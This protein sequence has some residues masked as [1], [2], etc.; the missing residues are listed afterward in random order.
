MK[1]TLNWVVFV[2]C[3][4]LFAV[5]F[6]CATGG[7]SKT[8]EGNGYLATGEWRPFFD[9]ENDGDSTATLTEAVETI[10]GET[11][12]TYTINGNVTTKY[13]YGFAGWA[14]D[15][16]D[17]TLERLKKATGISFYVQGDGK[18]YA[19]KYK[20]KECESDYCYYEYLFNTDPSGEPT[21]IEVPIKLFMQ[22]SW[23]AYKRLNQ[24]S[25]TGLEWQT[26]ESW[27]SSPSTNP[28]EVKIWDA[29]IWSN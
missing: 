21:L 2:L 16:D 14:I 24:D 6:S 17:E 25:F 1:K 13:Q 5:T 15:P 22:P 28:F 9:N 20:T 7:K 12:T 27:R 8:P 19:V 11:V 3:V 18:R 10:N 4:T 26:H 23:G 29:R